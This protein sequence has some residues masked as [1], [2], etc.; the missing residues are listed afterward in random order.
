MWLGRDCFLKQKGHLLNLLQKQ[1]KLNLQVSNLSPWQVTSSL[2]VQHTDKK[3]P[4]QDSSAEPSNNHLCTYL[5]SIQK[6]CRK[7]KKKETLHVYARGW[8]IWIHSPAY[9]WNRHSW[10]NTVDSGHSSSKCIK[11]SYA[12]CK[13]ICGP[14][15]RC[16]AA[17]SCP[18]GRY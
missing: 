7:C 6:T 11:D 3:Q 15:S 10:Q 1:L 14:I 16:W 2:K 8:N 12:N 5:P 18:H 17:C 9:G 4:C 13:H